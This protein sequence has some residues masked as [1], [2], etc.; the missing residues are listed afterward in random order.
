MKQNDKPYWKE[1]VECF[2]FIFIIMLLFIG[3]FIV[4]GQLTGTDWVS[5]FGGVSWDINTD[6]L[7]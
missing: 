5:Y 6:I 3:T 2:L 4:S 1:S 7:K